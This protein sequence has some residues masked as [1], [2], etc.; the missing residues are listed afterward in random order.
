MVRKKRK[1][2]TS[3]QKFVK[4]TKKRKHEIRYALIIGIFIGLRVWNPGLIDSVQ[5][6]ALQSINSTTIF[7]KALY[8]ELYGMLNV[9]I[10][11]GGLWVLWK[12]RQD[13]RIK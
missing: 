11:F 8:A 10:T 6:Q 5:D 13:K 2:L 9:I 1:P 12:H 7:L 3:W 4:W